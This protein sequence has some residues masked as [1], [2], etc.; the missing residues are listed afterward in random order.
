MSPLGPSATRPL[1]L[2]GGGRG[3]L[4]LDI[5]L[6]ALAWAG[7]VAGVSV[8]AAHGGATF[9][10]REV[11]ATVADYFSALA[12]DDGIEACAYLSESYR[13][14]LVTETGVPNCPTFIHVAHEQLTPAQLNRL[15][16]LDIDASDV[17][18]YE[19]RAS[20]R[21]SSGQGSIFVLEKVG[22]RWVI[23]SAS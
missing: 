7:Y 10:Q 3:L 13:R 19:G 16:S 20:L 17:I 1:L 4:V 14:L 15:G 12:D 2:S 23:D 5:V 9:Q 18:V 22:N 8:A 11:A 21:I 6:G